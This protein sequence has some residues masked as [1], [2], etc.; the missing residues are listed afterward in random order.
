MDYKATLNLPQTEFP[1]KANLGTR[2]PEWLKTWDAMKLYPA[3][4]EA[5][6][7][8]PPYILHDGPPYA[9]GSIHMGHILN[10]I[11][12]DFVVKY[13]N[14][15]GFEAHYIP[16]WDCHG[17][18]IEHQVDKD[19]GPKKQGMSQY[20]IRQACRAYAQKYVDK[21]RE[22]F[23]RLG[24]FGD[25]QNPYLTMD[26]AY[27]ATIAREFAKFVRAGSV[28]KGKKPV[29]WCAHCQ[30]AL[31]E[32]EIEYQEVSSPSIFVK[33]ELSAAG[34]QQIPK[35]A[36]QKNQ[37]VFV[38]I[39][40]TT[41]W[42]LPANLAI[43]LHPNYD[44]VALEG[45]D[46]IYIVAKELSGTLSRVLG[47]ELKVLDRFSAKRLEGHKCHHPFLNRDSLIVLG[48]HVTMEAGTG[49]VHTAPGHGQEDFEVG[50]EYKLPPLNPVDH[51]G[52]FTEE[53]G[54]KELEGMYVFKANGRINEIL[55]EKKAL[56]KEEAITHSYPHCWRCKQKVLFRATE[57][58]FISMER[59][60]L[61]E[62][63]LDSIRRVNWVPS[64]G[65]ERLTGMV[66]NR[67]DWCL[68]RQRSWGVPV[69]GFVCESCQEI[70]LDADLIEFVATI[71]EKEG[72]DAWF[73]HPVSEL[74]PPKT[75]CKKCGKDKFKKEQD[76]LDVWFDSG[77][78][79]AAVTEKRL[80]A[81]ADLYLEGSDQHRGWFQSS[82]LASLGTRGQAPYKAVI[83]HGMVVD[84]EGRKY[85]KSAKN[86]MPIEGLITQYGVDL[87]RLW[88]A[89]EDYSSDISVSNEIMKRLSEAYRKIR[90][91]ARYLLGN[92]DGYEPQGPVLNATLTD[93][94]AFWEIDRWILHALQKLITRSEAAYETFSFHTIFQEVNRFCTVELSSIY[95]DI[96][97][98]RLYT[99][100]KKHPE[101][102]AA[103][104]TLFQII[105]T[106]TRILAP[107]LSFTADE[108][109]QSIPAWKGKEASVHL[110]S[111]PK[112]EPYWLNESLA[113]RWQNFWT[114]REE[115]NKALEKARAVK[116]IGNSL[117]AK[118]HIHAQNA[119]LHLLEAFEK[120]LADLFLVSQVE[121]HK[122]PLKEATYKSS[123]PVLEFF[124]TKA[125]GQK[126]E[127]CWNYRTRIGKNK[128]HPTLCER[129]T[130]AV[131]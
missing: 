99:F 84:G 95:C 40:T 91:T 100:P 5:N 1:M 110:C 69:I 29:L 129:C 94:A 18:P 116:L 113:D 87:L 121:L 16:G 131:T 125:E 86:Y 109:W 26:F 73:K 2:E 41:P 34:Q 52:C 112:A 17:L 96:L 79:F 22:E 50:L 15:S 60:D 97:K 122:A 37:K 85:S 32:A 49:C 72:C 25:W 75:H 62:K 120:H 53:V 108:I 39:W 82:L 57:Q 107:I 33:F 43:A 71:F 63:A 48:N 51:R 119:P 31:A 118:L 7:G 81:M 105:T 14:M 92:L 46:E 127:R 68:S 28:Y 6:K 56:I 3:I 111:F 58:W 128:E 98:D 36:D 27:E 23:K 20:D 21:Q 88:V 59:N 126:C 103:Q 55:T 11:L 117:E 83:T 104:H 89:S 77:V 93:T 106:L 115:A 13:K 8:K 78:S 24:V 42:T 67:P 19:L 102:L 65:R 4:L 80:G 114:V 90:N 44:Y 10:K 123:L 61:R 12:K 130:E 54:L 66:Q 45:K 30:T 74:V 35:L 101:R 38:V 9:N 64:W 47:M 124:V 70:L 76:I